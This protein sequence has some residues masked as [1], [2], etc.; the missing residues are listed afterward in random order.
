[1]SEPVI[2]KVD[3]KPYRLAL[4]FKRTYK[5]YSL[6]L[7]DVRSDKY[8]GTDTP[9]DYSSM[10]RLR[11]DSPDPALKVDR[12]DVRIWMNNPLRFHGETFYQS[13]V[14]VDPITREETTGLQVVSNAG[15]MIPYVSCMIVA[16]GMLFQFSVTLLRFLNRLQTNDL[17]TDNT[18]A[19]K[20]LVVAIPA[21][22]ALMVAYHALPPRPKEGS[23]DLYAA[24]KI[25]VMYQGRMKPLDTLA[26]NTL[27]VL[28]NR[29]TFKDEGKKS[30]PA[31]RWL[32]DVISGSEAA[33][34]HRVFRIDNLDVLERL[35]LEWREGHLYSLEEF[36]KKADDFNADVEQAGKKRTEQLS[37][38]ERKLLELDRRIRA[39]TA[40]DA[41]FRRPDLPEPDER[42]R[43]MSRERR[44][45]LTQRLAA[46]EESL[47]K[48]HPPLA[49]PV[50]VGTDSPAKYEWKPLVSAFTR[51]YFEAR[52]F[53]DRPP[54]PAVAA[55]AYQAAAASGFFSV[56]SPARYMSPTLAMAVTSPFS[57]AS[58]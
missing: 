37:V 47:R 16:V 50:R 21:L 14:G 4:R 2:V 36:R 10:V 31:I 24:G 39:Y 13:N 51:D 40:I 9:K 26:R 19:G 29:E 3:E 8:M 35:G 56:H 34:K 12:D 54:D 23:L 49:V 27:Q 1:M 44:G 45:A 52:V 17:G 28:S 32:F 58:R 7:N 33:E 48:G 18:F 22:C 6:K 30:Q 5:P 57:A 43:E 25:P 53:S 38:Y 46:A 55:R 15:W 20:C 11:M 42:I 41:S